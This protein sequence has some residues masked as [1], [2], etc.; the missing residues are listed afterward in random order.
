MAV[1]GGLG[2]GEAAR[3]AQE[4]R[5]P[6][7]VVASGPA[8]GAT[9]SKGL[10]RGL[11]TLTA[12]GLALAVAES[13]RHMGDQDIV[14]LIITTFAVGFA[15][16]LIKVHPQMKLY[17][18]GLRVFLLTFCYVTVSGYNTGEFVG[19]TAVS[20]FLL[21]VIGGAV[22]L[23]VNIGIYPIWAGE[24]LHHLVARNFA[25]VAESLEGCVDGYLTCMEYQRVPSKILTYQASDDPLYSGY[26]AAVEAQT[27]EE[28]LLG[29]AIWEPPHGPY[30]MMK[31]PWQS[32]T[33]V[34]GALR[35]CSFAVM[36][37]H[38]CILSEIQSAPENRQVFSAE[39]HRVGDEAAKVLRELGHR[40]KT[41]TRL[42]SPNILSE[43]LHAAEELQKKIDQRSY[44]LVNTDRWGEDTAAST[45]TCSRHEAGAGA[46]RDNEAPPPPSEHA[47]IIN[48]PPMHDSES[49]TSLA[50]IASVNVPPLHKSESNTTL[51]RA[52]GESESTTTL[53][54]AAALGSMHKSESNTSLARFDSAASWAAMSLADGLALKPQGSWHHRMPPFHPGQPLEAAESRTYESAS[55]LSLGTFASLLIEFVAR[56]GN[57][58]NAVEELSDKAGFKDPVEQPSVLSREETGVFGRMTKF[59]RQKR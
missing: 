40:V 35:H 20:R 52:A 2:K 36:A 34:G 27:Q 13:A 8:S 54:R 7:A 24:D 46:S 6:Q 42:S 30:K 49:N 12:G 9:L 59:F 56:L 58:V 45:T 41:M 26:R 22:S 25:R 32:Y 57:L 21:I 39:L 18:Y 37:L 1:G 11:G 48:I 47:V 3:L 5:R 44:L 4:H 14:F 16:T 38:G 15:T 55:A 31:Y 51:A 23:A 50:R 33:K 19:G 17:E 43:V 28:T 10:N 29:F 53:A